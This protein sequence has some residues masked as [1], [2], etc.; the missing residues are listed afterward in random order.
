VCLDGRCDGCLM[1]VDGVPSVLTCRTPARDGTTVATQNVLGSA[2]VDLLGITDYAFPGHLDHHHMF[3]WSGPVNRAM[4]RVARQIAG[5]GTLPEAPIEASPALERRVD[6]LVVGAGPAGLRA[7][8]RLL[9]AGREVLL[10]EED[11]R[12][13]GSLLRRAPERIPP[14]VEGVARAEV[15]LRHA[16]LAVFPPWED[17]GGTEGPAP[18]TRTDRWVAVVA[19]PRGLLR[20]RPG[21]LVLATGRGQSTWGIP[22][23][24]TPGVFALEAA[25]HLLSRG[26]LVG[27]RIAVFG[28]SPE[29]DPLLARLCAAGAEVAEPKPL[30][31]LLQV[32]GRPTVGSVRWRSTAGATVHTPCDAVLLAGPRSALHELAEQVGIAPRWAGDRWELDVATAPGDVTV[33][34][35]AVHG[36]VALEEALDAAD[37]MLEP[38]LA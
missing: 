8:A 11:D 37:R 23:D 25:G 30:A 13:G 26:V 9:E 24:D 5:I 22:G 15:R 7:T 27:Q 3:T 20:V 12:L 14:L 38:A 19:G 31:A 17:V 10:V 16:A 21:H 32:T 33:L 34:G 6:A 28:A 29:R 36:D 1:R 4:Q 2:R 18:S 35:D